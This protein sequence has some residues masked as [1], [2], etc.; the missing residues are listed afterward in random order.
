MVNSEIV[1]RCRWAVAHNHGHPSATW[2]TGEQLVVAL[3]LHDRAHLN[4]MHYTF[5]QAAEHL[6]E[7]MR[8][9]WN[10]LASWLA[11]IRAALAFDSRS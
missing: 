11:D 10:E 8:F 5:D 4:T 6:C 1:E 7:S 2:S 3:I 9:S